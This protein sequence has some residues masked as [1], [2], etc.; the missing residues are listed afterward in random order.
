MSYF[1]HILLLILLSMFSIAILTLLRILDFANIT[2]RQKIIVIKVGLVMISIAPLIF[3]ILRCLSPHAFAITLPVQFINELSASAIPIT[4]SNSEI[5]WTFY[6][7]IAYVSGLLIMLLRILL[8]YFSASK[9]LAGSRLSIIQEQSVFLNAHIQSPLSFGF[10]IAKIYFPAN[11]EET[12]TA[13][14]IE[15]CLAHERAH[16]EQFDPL[17]KLIS[18][19]V[20][21]LLFFSPASYLLHRRFEL[22]MEI[23]CDEKTCAKT[24]AEVKEYG[25]LLLAMTCV[26]PH[27]LIFTNITN[28]TLK[29]RLLAMKSKNTHRPFLISV[30]S[31]ALFLAGG[32][33]IATT[34][35]VFVKESIF[36]I[37]SKIFIDGKLVS[38]PQIVANANQKASIVLSN[39]DGGQG[40]RIELIA[41]DVAKHN[42]R[43]NYDI[44]Y[45]NGE[46][47]MHSKPEVVVI[48]NQEGIIR[49]ASDSGHLYEMKVIAERE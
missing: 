40:L 5:D 39:K 24:N 49:I 34:A 16:L 47:K 15:M 11:I 35:G 9:Q 1:S 31:I 14:E 6:I 22:E 7:F 8:S 42:I 13:R 48:P 37:T 33:A 10:P 23:L 17:W 2:S 4:S 12:W 46:E 43:I 44:Q 28:S 19:I 26:Q 25:S 36:K 27:N 21:A 3:T 18:H 20:Q 29:R 32:T 41:K 45:T 30:L 38:S